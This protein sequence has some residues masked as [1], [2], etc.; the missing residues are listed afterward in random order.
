MNVKG[1]TETTYSLTGL[2]QAQAQELLE[3]ACMD[4]EHVKLDVRE[5]AIEETLNNFRQA[6][7]SAGVKRMTQE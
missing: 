3:V 6:L 5:P 1:H 7:L 2:T 4:S